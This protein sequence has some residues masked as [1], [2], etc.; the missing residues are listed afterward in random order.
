VL[1]GLHFALILW[2]FCRG[3]SKNSIHG[4]FMEKAW[5]VMASNTPDVEIITAN[6]GVGK[7]HRILQIINDHTADHGY[8]FLCLAFN[9]DKSK[10]LRRRIKNSLPH[11]NQDSLQTVPAHCEKNVQTYTIHSLAYQFSK[12]RHSQLPANG[13]G[14]DLSSDEDDFQTTGRTKAVQEKYDK[15]LVDFLV[16]DLSHSNDWPVLANIQ[17]LVVDEIQDLKY[18]HIA[19]IYKLVSQLKIPRVILSGD[20]NQNI[21]GSMFFEESE[22]LQR[23]A[24]NIL[25]QF[26]YQGETAFAYFNAIWPQAKPLPIPN[27]P[28]RFE[29]NLQI[30]RIIDKWMQG[31]ELSYHPYLYHSP[32][33]EPSI[34]PRLLLTKNLQ[35]TKEILL[36]EIKRYFK[37]GIPIRGTRSKDDLPLVVLA[38]TN[39]ECNEIDKYLRE[40][41]NLP[42]THQV[43]TE[44][45]T[46]L[47][48]IKVTTIHK[49]K[50]EQAK[51]VF[52]I[53]LN[54]DFL[55]SLSSLTLDERNILRSLYYVG[56]SR[57]NRALIIITSHPYNFKHKNQQTARARV[58]TDPITVGLRQLTEGIRVIGRQPEVTLPGPLQFRV[59]DARSRKQISWEQFSNLRI[60]RISITVPRNS[61][62]FLPIGYLPAYSKDALKTTYSDEELGMRGGVGIDMVARRRGPIELSPAKKATKPIE[63]SFSFSDLSPLHFVRGDDLVALRH[64]AWMMRRFFDFRISPDSFRITQ[65]TLV[66]VRQF[67]RNPRGADI[68]CDEL[69]AH[70]N[71][72]HRSSNISF[73]DRKNSIAQLTKLAKDF[74]VFKRMPAKIDQATRNLVLCQIDLDKIDLSLLDY[75]TSVH[76]SSAG[77]FW[78]L[79]TTDQKLY[80]I[81]STKRTNGAF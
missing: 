19:V 1:L 18:G 54:T 26:G 2:I 11:K 30:P 74:K 13:T 47:S 28:K 56:L 9:R 68:F 45:E 73:Y 81:L 46:R 61:M 22:N 52:L 32:Q 36:S 67:T 42:S 53:N 51:V 3:Q 60:L 7:T 57:A 70:K 69:R 29:S 77:A 49:F 4:I 15:M 65:L 59:L 79:I 21:Y 31:A 78:P 80:E 48:P 8:N 5:S 50:G 12:F 66:S 20:R 63:V 35:E 72:L 76:A 16:Q 39:W 58:H 38:Y 44:P 25:S 75:G 34:R 41:G 24:K 37:N 71:G 17:L 64:C 14:T 6:A 43:E 27:R 40:N 23:H 55:S 33:V 10:S 62:P